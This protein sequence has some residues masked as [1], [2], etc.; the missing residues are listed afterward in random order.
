MNESDLEKLLSLGEGTELECKKATDTCP[1]AVW[2]TYSAFANTNGGCILLGV[3]E[4]RTVAGKI[5]F[6]VTGIQNTAKVLTEFWNAI[7]SDKVSVNLL[8]DEDVKI[9]DIQG[10]S[11]ISIYVPPADY[12]NRPVYING[13]P[14]K[15]TYRRAHEGDYHCREAEIKSMFRDAADTGND[16]G[17]LEGFTIEDVDKDTLQSY[18]R[19]F[20]YNHPDHVWNRLDDVDFLR[21]LGAMGKDRK[22][23]KIWLTTAGLL[24]LGTGM[25]IRERFS[26]IRMDYLDKTN[27]SPGSRWSHRLTYDGMWEN[28]LYQFIRRLLPWLVD[29]VKRPFRMEGIIRQDDT[30]VH[31]ALREAVI[32]MVIHADYMMTGLLQV[33]KEDTKITFANPGLLKLPPENIYEGGHAVARNPILQNMLRMIGLGENIGSGFPKILSAWSQAGWPRPEIYENRESG[34]VEL[35]LKM[36]DQREKIA[37]ITTDTATDA[38]ILAALKNGATKM[39]DITDIVG[40]SPSGTAK[41]VNKLISEGR[42]SRKRQGRQVFYT[43]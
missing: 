32:N 14:M 5:D 29:G 31:I 43:L 17:I 39:K 37:D 20:E 12:R 34:S 25:A 40:L 6:L 16:V 27:L 26:N 19:E 33:I 36:E 2:E 3:T 35:V 4:K 11:V 23:G 15:G 9:I 1:K 8:L 22:T 24:L 38:A 30:P 21:N 18:R 13:N 28:N 41:A 10:K 42:I 7:N